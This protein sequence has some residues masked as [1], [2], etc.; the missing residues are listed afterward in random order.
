MWQSPHNYR[1][2]SASKMLRVSEGLKHRLNYFKG[3]SGFV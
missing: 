2:T 1:G 3:V